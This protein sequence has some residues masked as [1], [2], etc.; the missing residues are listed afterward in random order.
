M[1]DPFVAYVDPGV[2]ATLAQLAV[3]GTAGIIAAGKLRMN[4]LK[5][6]VANDGEAKA[7]KVARGPDGA[8]APRE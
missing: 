7:A 3:A 2:G 5:R 8:A 1:I 6:R 4:K